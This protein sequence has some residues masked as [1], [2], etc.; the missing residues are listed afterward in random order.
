MMNGSRRLSCTISGRQVTCGTPPRRTSGAARSSDLRQA[1]GSSSRPSRASQVAGRPL[2]LSSMSRNSYSSSARIPG[3]LVSETSIA[4]RP[5][6][7]EHA[8]VRD[9]F[10]AA[11]V[12]AGE[13]AP[14]VADMLGRDGGGEAHRAR[15]TASLQQRRDLRGLGR[16]RRAFHRFLA[17]REMTKRRQRSE[18]AE[19]DAGTA[20]RG[21]VHEL[22]KAFPV[23]GDT[24]AQDVERNR[25]DVDQVPRRYFPHFGPARRDSHAA[26][27]HH[28]RSHAVP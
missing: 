28:D 19:V 21:G 9:Q 5:S 6:S 20:A 2:A 23:P 1:S 10:I 24:L 26:V 3:A 8:G 25:L 14:L 22:R 27:T 18:E 12:A 11:G 15:A 17:H 4:P 13:R 7:L 16:R